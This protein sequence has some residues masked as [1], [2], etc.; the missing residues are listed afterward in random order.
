MLLAH[1]HQGKAAVG[2]ERALARARG[3]FCVS[4][5]CLI[6]LLESRTGIT[7]PPPAACKTIR[8][9]SA[10]TLRAFRPGL[11]TTSKGPAFLRGSAPPELDGTL[12]ST[13]LGRLT[14][15]CQRCPSCDD[16]ARR[17]LIARCGSSDAYK[18][19]SVQKDR[20]TSSCPSSRP[21]VSFPRV[22]VGQWP[23]PSCLFWVWLR[24]PWLSSLRRPCAL[25]PATCRWR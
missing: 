7:A 18:T 24:W 11:S 5:Q 14:R 8:S 16:C 6:V 4:T 10:P 25:A 3:R 1:D 21:G 23:W 9:Q 12:T 13:K 2:I 19:N 22:A 20:A 15:G 17:P